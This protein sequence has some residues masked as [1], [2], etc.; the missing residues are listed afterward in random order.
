[1]TWSIKPRFLDIEIHHYLLRDKRVKL[2][3]GCIKSKGYKN[4]S[5]WRPEAGNT[6][7]LMTKYLLSG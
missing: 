5:M 1:M 7:V 6:G 2:L 3:A 4:I